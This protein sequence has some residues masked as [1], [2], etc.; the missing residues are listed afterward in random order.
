M[1]VLESRTFKA[2]LDNKVYGFELPAGHALE[3]SWPCAE[4]GVPTVCDD[5]LDRSMAAFVE[6][7]AQAR[8]NASLVLEGTKDKVLKQR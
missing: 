2:Y 6:A 1:I 4:H 3:L 5:G 7:R 8:S